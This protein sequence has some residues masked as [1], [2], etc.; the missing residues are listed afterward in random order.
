MTV[1]LFHQFFLMIFST[2]LL[3]EAATAVSFSLS[4]RQGFAAYLRARDAEDLTAAARTLERRLE[5]LMSPSA[6][7]RAPI[8]LTA[9]LAA[10]DPRAPAFPRAAPPFGPP[11]FPPPQSPLARPDRPGFPRPPPT[12]DDAGRP[13]DLG[14][15]PPGGAGAPLNARPP[16][17]GLGPRLIVEDETG[18]WAGGPP[19][20]AANGPPLSPPEALR[21]GGRLVGYVAVLP[22]GPA[23]DGVEARFL[24]AQ[25]QSLLI[26][27]G[28]VIALSLGLSIL[29]ARVIARPLEAVGAAT[30]KIAAG[31]FSVE[32]AE[33]GGQEVRETMANINAMAAALRRLDA[34]R[35]LW[36][37][38]ISHELRTPLAGLRGELEA[39]L[40]GVR[41][42]GRPGVASAAEEVM[43]LGALVDDLHLLAVSD[44]EGLR[45]KPEPQDAAA[46]VRAA[47]ERR[48]RALEGQGLVLSLDIDDPP[49]P[50]RWDEGRITQVLDNLLSNAV[51]YT[52]AP[53]EIRVRLT[54]QGERVRLRIDDTAPCPADV[55]LARLLEPLYRADAD[56]SRSAGGSGMGLAICDSIVRAH[57]GAVS[58][59]PSPLGG[60]S[61]TVDLPRT[62]A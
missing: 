18:A 37:A 5:P 30:R 15:P 59:E 11:P 55:H 33:T 56:R 4:L 35:R 41:P 42:I 17:E 60:L 53:G 45:L 38:E 54:A 50:V 46:L 2:A 10:A 19:K 39:M 8:S 12:E 13:R 36:L 61:V 24:S 51:R 28:L 6:D 31:D 27:S 58:L 26:L 62:A 3:V 52:D 47:V 34:A 32:V 1:K 25:I 14:P 48:R 29:A 9:A 43:T 7:G 23:P 44:L 20:P 57:K 16:P 22:R 49:V 21:V 40:D